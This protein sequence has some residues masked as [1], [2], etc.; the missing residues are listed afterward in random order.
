MGCVQQS[1]YVKDRRQVHT[2][3]HAVISLIL[4][5]FTPH[6]PEQLKQFLTFNIKLQIPTLA[7]WFHF[8]D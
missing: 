7:A 4:K 8:S 3:L 5:A 1:V 2:V 6:H